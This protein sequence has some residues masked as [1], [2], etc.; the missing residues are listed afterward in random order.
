MNRLSGVTSQFRSSANYILKPS[1]ASELA[2]PNAVHGQYYLYQYSTTGSVRGFSE[3]PH[4]F[5]MLRSMPHSPYST[6]D[7]ET[8]MF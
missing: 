2:A 6:T 3:T 7:A 5:E 1:I 8:T 4:V